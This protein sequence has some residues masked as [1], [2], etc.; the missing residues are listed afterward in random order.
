MSSETTRGPSPGRED[1]L[2][3]LLA[4]LRRQGTWAEWDERRG[5]AAIFGGRACREVSRDVLSRAE[6]RAA[7]AAGLLETHGDNRWGLSRPARQK[8]RRLR[9][10]P[11]PAQG[12]SAAGSVARSPVPVDRPTVNHAESPLAWL[13]QRR[14]KHGVAMITDAQFDAGERL[15]ADHGLAQL[16]PR[17]TTSWTQ[18]AGKCRSAPSS[19]G[20][21]ISDAAIA[22]R[23]RVQRALKAVGPE[24][25][26]VLI[27]IC[28]HLKG[29]EHAE[30]SAGWPQRSGKVVLQIALTALARHYGLEK[31]AS[32]PETGRIRHWG[33]AGFRPRI[34]GGAVESE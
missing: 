32:A 21:D 4:P 26:G 19:A 2:L 24:L 5:Q 1:E 29:L 17:V 12:R 18:P 13:R 10:T 28:C 11:A 33:G 23:E 31:N 30:R 22:A 34:D 9:S 8:L 3:R 7:V 16:M 6:W 27:D 14:D 20:I 15:R 25:A